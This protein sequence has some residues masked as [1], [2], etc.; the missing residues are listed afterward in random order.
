MQ[1]NASTP[2]NQAR[3]LRRD[4]TETERRLWARLRARQ[5]RGAKFRRQ[6]PI[7]R[8]IADF[9]C[10]EY[11]LVI[12][13]D[14]GQHAMRAEVDQRRSAFLGRRG[15]RVLRFWDNQVLEDIDAVLEKIVEALR[16]PHP[17][18]LPGRERV[19][20]TLALNPE[21]KQRGKDRL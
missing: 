9:C 12:E 19:N 5:L 18:P 1:L 20:N 3:R 16:D 21:K 17:Y 14:G 6:H 13:L 8:F 2:R 4:Q 15:F 7:G 10:L 11:G